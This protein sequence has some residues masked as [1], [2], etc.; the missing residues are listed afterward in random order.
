MLENS[1]MG[2][3]RRVFKGIFTVNRIL[4]P[5]N[6]KDYRN[7]SGNDGGVVSVKSGNDRRG[8]VVAFGDDRCLKRWFGICCK[9]FKYPSPEAKA[10]TSPSRGEVTGLLRFARNDVH[11]LGRSMIEMLGVLAIIGVLSVTG[12]AG[13]SKAMEKWKVNK[14]LDEYSMLI[15]GLLQDIDYIKKL[16][17]TNVPDNADEVW[18]LNYAEGVGLIPNNWQK[19]SGKVTI[20][21]FGNQLH[22]FARNNRLV[23]DIYLRGSSTDLCQEFYRDLIKPLHKV[24]YFG[25]QLRGNASTFYGDNYCNDENLK[26]INSLTLS[27]IQ[28][29]CKKCENSCALGLEF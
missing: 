19:L 10:S 5:A 23:F 24:L 6:L 16:N 25:R 4:R 29:M 26:C 12:I 9:F 11:C 27:D 3:L 20:D 14:A 7:K 17:T 21:T 2:L 13:Y 18:L 15:Y 22:I 8:E 1:K 28:N